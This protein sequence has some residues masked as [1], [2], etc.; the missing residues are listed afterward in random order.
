MDKILIIAWNMIRRSIGTFR[1]LMVFILLP[2]IVVA[3][4]IS[5]T[6]GMAEGPATVLYANSD[7]GA[8]GRH[9]ITELEQAGEYKFEPR[10]DEAALKEATIKQEGTVGVF[11]PAGYTAALMAGDPLQINIYELRASESSIMMKMKITATAA[12]IAEAAHTVAAASG[13]TGDMQAQLAAVLKQSEQHNVG[14]TRTDYDLYPRQTLGVVTGMTL[15]FL[16]ALV[17][18]S[19]SQITDDRRGRTMMRMFSAPVRSYEIALGNFLGSFLVGMIQI[20]VVLVL[21]KWVLR[22]DYEM[23]LFLYFLVLA[24]F[25]LVSMGIASTVAGLIRNPR[26]AGM[27]NSLI[28][29]PTCMLGGCFWPVSIMPEYMQK[30]A[31]F[32]PQ[33]WAIQAVDIAATGGG[34]NEL[35][36]PFAILGLMAAVLLAIGSAI[37]RPNE[38]GIST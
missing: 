37:L 11:I 34:W 36:M 14:S 3:A 16:M 5:L 2:G 35:W 26:N 32:T 28:L 4:I 6:G 8:A 1:G 31:N 22:Y 27:L 33:K 9:L 13:G 18:S 38:A 17:T 29:T 23:P 10:G 30:L 24:A 15:M 19:V 21:G 7:T 20:L 25:M 12:Q